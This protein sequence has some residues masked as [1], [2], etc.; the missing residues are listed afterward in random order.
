MKYFSNEDHI[1]YPWTHVSINSLDIKDFD[2]LTEKENEL[3]LAA[4]EFFYWSIDKDTVFDENYLKLLHKHTFEKLYS[5]AWEYRKVNI[6]KWDSVFCQVAHLGSYSKDIFE[7]LEKDNYLRDCS[8]KS[9]E[10]FAK[11]LSYYMCEL[12]ALH[13]FN[14][15]NWRIIRLFFDMICVYNWYKYIDYSWINFEWE[16]NDYIEASIACMKWEC[17]LMEKIVLKWLKK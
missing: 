16:S 17:D 10:E 9:K 15:W 12:I 5:W 8:D 11:K 14:E 13:P 4:N 6:S 7:K 2:D 1:Y 3:L